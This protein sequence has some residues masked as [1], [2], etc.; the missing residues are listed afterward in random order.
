MWCSWI[1]VRFM[2][3]VGGP[4]KGISF[5]YIAALVSEFYWLV[6]AFWCIASVGSDVGQRPNRQDP[7]SGPVRGG[8][9]SL[10]RCPFCAFCGVVTILWV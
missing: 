7:D 6:G 9:S 2:R 8:G 1:I 4:P 3:F 10:A 5:L